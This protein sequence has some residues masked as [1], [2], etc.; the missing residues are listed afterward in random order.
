M[1]YYAPVFTIL[2]S[3]SVDDGLTEGKDNRE[4]SESVGLGGGA[5]GAGEGDEK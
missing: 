4:P 3:Q 1:D 2:S 5:G